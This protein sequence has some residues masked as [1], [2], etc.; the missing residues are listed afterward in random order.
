MTTSAVVTQLRSYTRP[1]GTTVADPKAGAARLRDIAA[2][3]A[4][5]LRQFGSQANDNTT[6]AAAGAPRPGQMAIPADLSYAKMDALTAQLKPCHYALRKADGTVSFFEVSEY[7]SKSRIVLLSGAPGRYRWH[8]MKLVTQYMAVKHILDD[9]A[10]AVKLYADEHNV[11][12]KCH[13]PLT[14]AHSRAIGLGPVCA[15]KVL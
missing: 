3:Q 4:A 2:D 6:P 15:G 14:D 8:F 9:P 5:L 11:C 13:S 10:A 1:A 12:S 7:K